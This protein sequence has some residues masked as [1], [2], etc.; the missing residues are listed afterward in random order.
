MNKISKGAFIATIVLLSY[1]NYAKA[2]EVSF[3]KPGDDTGD[4]SA[5]VNGTAPDQRLNIGGIIGGIV[6]NLPQGHGGPGNPGGHGGF[7]PNPPAPVNPGGH[8]NHGGPGPQPGPWQPQPGPVH[9]DGP[10]P[11]PGPWNPHP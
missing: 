5:Q 7:N 8:G 2:L 11:Q 6:H 1:T 3:D 4:L 10:G 9:H